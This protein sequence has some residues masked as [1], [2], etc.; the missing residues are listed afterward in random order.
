MWP[1]VAAVSAGLAVWFRVRGDDL[2]RICDQILDDLDVAEGEL[3]LLNKQ[4]S[5]VMEQMKE[6]M[7]VIVEVSGV[8]S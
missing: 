8:Q 2:A 4:H 3:S 1:V 6:Q 7:K 5:V